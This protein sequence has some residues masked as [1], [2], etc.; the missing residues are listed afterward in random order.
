MTLDL[1][2][3]RFLGQFGLSLLFLLMLAGHVGQAYNLFFIEKLDAALYDLKMRIFR[4][5]TVEERVVVVD[6]DDKSLREIGRWPWPRDQVA[7]LTR[8]LFEQY[9]VAAIGYDVVF[10]EPDQS[11]G[12]PVLEKMAQ[13]PLAGDAG[14][15]ASLA[16]IRPRLD[17]DGKFAESL[18]SGAAIMGYYFNFAPP[19]EV[20][21]QLPT[22]LFPCAEITRHGVTPRHA[23]GYNANLK[24]LQDRA[25]GAAFYNMEADFDGVARRMPVLMEYDGQCYGSLAFMSAS[26]GMGI[27]APRI[28]PA[29]GYRP[30]MLDLDG[31]L[32]P[33]DAQANALVPYRAANAFRYVSATDVIHEREPGANLEGRIV[34]IGSTA[35]GIM[36]LRVTPVS[37]ILPGVEIH[38]SLVSGILDGTVKWEPSGVR[39]M[40]LATIA[41]A[42]LFLAALLPI[43]S[44]L[45]AALVTVLMGVLVTGGNL[46]AWS[47]WH[48]QLP[49]AASL[50]AVLGLFVLN[51]SYGF[52]VEARSKAQITKLFGQYISP[53]LVDEMAK[54]PA[55]YSLRGESRV[56]TVL[57]S[58]IVSFTSFSEKLEAAQLAEMLNMYLSAMTRIV[59]EGRGTIDKYIGDAIMAFWGA[60]MSDDQHA[61][62]AVL[63]ALAM[64][65]GLV[66]LNPRLEARGWPPVKIGVGVNTGRM[67]VGNMGSEFRMAYTVMA[68]AVNLASRLEALTRQY[69]VGVLAGETTRGECPDL[70]F[71]IID[72]VRV[73]AKEVPV[74][75]YE[76]L[77][78][79]TELPAER[80]KEAALFEAAFADYQARRWDEAEI[81]LMELG[82][83][84]QRK[85]YQVYLDRV[86]HFRFN[87]P[88]AEWDGV[89]TY[90]TK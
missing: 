60:P 15:A 41:I 29:A 16:R 72:R 83:I 50:L 71:Q 6:I 24:I 58:D 35:P 34:L 48:A 68:D 75:I 51:M 5:Q 20:N 86:T 85:L 36:D 62:D 78:V 66:E 56:M 84:A 31:L 9:G 43:I 2:R 7:K 11:S 89:F 90:T 76:P 46:Y 74:A 32:V 10:S 12:L 45:W 40:E 73:K 55:R 59:Q 54:D 23:V 21:G 17:Y 52:F 1:R 57:F 69:G 63:V 81:K 3:R 80:L 13:G 70:T 30:T 65:A 64:Q 28:I 25:F 37:K 27:D 67:S 8:N 4:P 42:G 22:P 79:T 44:P 82:K 61:R 19:V 38:A 77:G 39:G 33:L 87:P 53:E 47:A 88:P 14:F 49:L 18:E 26:A